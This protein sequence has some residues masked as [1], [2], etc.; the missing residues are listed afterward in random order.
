MC[1]PSQEFQSRVMVNTTAAASS[2]TTA[3][4]PYFRHFDSGGAVACSGAAAWTG[5][6]AGVDA[7]AISMHLRERAGTYEPFERFGVGLVAKKKGFS[8]DATGGAGVESF[9]LCP[10]ECN[11][12]T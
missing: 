10:K 2:N 9:N 4:T 3:G 6:G 11:W 5:V 8:T 7:E 12:K 1:P